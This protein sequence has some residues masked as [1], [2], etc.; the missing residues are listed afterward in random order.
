MFLDD[1][2]EP[3]FCEGPPCRHF[4]AWITSPAQAQDYLAYKALK[5]ASVKLGGDES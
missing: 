1:E 4:P 2:P 3:D 5:E